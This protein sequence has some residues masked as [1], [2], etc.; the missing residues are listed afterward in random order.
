MKM[1]ARCT[2]KL[3]ATLPLESKR[4]ATTT[5]TLISQPIVLAMGSSVFLTVPPCQFMLSA[6]KTPSLRL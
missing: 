1:S 3:M 5:G 2:L 6:L 4:T